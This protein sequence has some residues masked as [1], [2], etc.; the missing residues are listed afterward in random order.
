MGRT[1]RTRRRT[2]MGRRTVDDREVNGKGLQVSLPFKAIHVFTRSLLFR[3]TVV[4]AIFCPSVPFYLLSFSCSKRS[5]KPNT[6]LEDT[7][8]TTFDIAFVPQLTPP[9]SS[10]LGRPL[11]VLLLD[12][13]EL[14]GS[15]ILLGVEDRGTK[16]EGNLSTTEAHNLSEPDIF[17]PKP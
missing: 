14:E 6:K 2:R 11:R 17:R 9:S 16:I 8:T 15:V 1:G 10:S 4:L 13:L 12:S 7:M 5:T 3:A